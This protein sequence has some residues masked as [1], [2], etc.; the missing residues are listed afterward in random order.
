MQAIDFTTNET[1][2]FITVQRQ[3]LNASA[4]E[5]INAYLQHV[6]DEDASV[7][8]EPIAMLPAQER[9]EIEA[10]LSLM[11]EDECAPSLRFRVTI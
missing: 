10:A 8:V 6:I 1:T 2:V 3:A 7:D 5:K 11:S 4:I 9:E